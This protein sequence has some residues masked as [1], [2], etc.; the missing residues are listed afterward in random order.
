MFTNEY[1]SNASRSHSPMSNYSDATSINS[2]NGA[3]LHSLQSDEG[4][5]RLWHDSPF[6]NPYGWTPFTQH[7][8]LPSNKQ[9]ISISLAMYNNGWNEVA[10]VN[11]NGVVAN[12]G[13]INKTIPMSNCLFVASPVVPF[14]YDQ[15]IGRV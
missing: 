3:I 13:T 11:R 14:A 15:S 12:N 4:A 5:G 9:P 10:N 8:A 6:F 2:S 7:G 1:S